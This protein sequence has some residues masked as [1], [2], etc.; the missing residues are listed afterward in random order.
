MFGRL[1]G[2]WAAEIF[3]SNCSNCRIG[4]LLV[5]DIGA[6]HF[7]VPANGRNKVSPRP[8]F[9]AQ[10]ILYLAFDILR[11]SYRTLS[12]HVSDDLIA[13]CWQHWAMRN[14]AGVA[15]SI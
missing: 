4:Q 13:P 11:D 2:F 8:E 5:S 10:K 15:M 12:F 3:S 7:L 14:C 1:T 6:D 9:V